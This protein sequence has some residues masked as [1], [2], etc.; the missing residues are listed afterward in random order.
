MTYPNRPICRHSDL[1]IP[2]LPRMTPSMVDDLSRWEQVAWSP[3]HLTSDPSDTADMLSRFL[4]RPIT[5]TTD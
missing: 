4:S 2:D 5:T 1:I 3:D